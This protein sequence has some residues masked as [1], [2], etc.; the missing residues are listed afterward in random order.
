VGDHVFFYGTLMSPFNRPG[1]QRITSKLTFEG[2]GSMRAA[3]FDLG[4]Y[5]AA[6]PV[7]DDSV[8]WGEVYQ[9][10]EAAPVLAVLDEIEGYRPNEPDRSLYTR[11]L[12]DVTLEDGRVEKAW[13][14]FYNAPLGR[15]QRI[16]S[17]DY[18]EHLN[19]K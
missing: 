10:T 18:L 11:V 3:L 17:G 8:V 5:P 7:E 2:R 6:V 16:E 4:I 19:V 14:Y 13:A 15:A 9:T 12:T 1:R